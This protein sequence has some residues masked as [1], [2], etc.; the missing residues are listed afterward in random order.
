MK[1]VVVML[2]G[3]GV[4]DGS[5]IHE[6]VLTLLALD[7]AG[8]EVI[9]AA[10]DMP[11]Y[12]VINHQLK[13]PSKNESRNVREESA[14]IAREPV[15][16]LDEIA[17]DDF[18]AVIVPGGFGAAKNLCTFAHEAELCN[19]NPSV[20]SFLIKAHEKHKPMGFMC[21]ATAIAARLFGHENLQF[22]IGNDAPTAAALQTWGGAHVNCTADDVVVDLK[23]KIVTTPA[24]MLATRIMEAEQGINELVHAVLKMI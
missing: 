12:H 22:T 13:Q 11:Q 7:K 15:K 4:F 17:A 18:D 21:I 10:P 23:H 20:S 19:V 1:R 9:Y 8:A 24:Y 3:C 6:A 16:Q 2:A 14:R 5:E